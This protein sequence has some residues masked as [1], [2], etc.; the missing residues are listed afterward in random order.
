MLGI[1][2]RCGA[3]NKGQEMDKWEISPRMGLK[4]YLN[5]GGNVTIEQHDLMGEDSRVVV[6]QDD[7]PT[8]IRY[9]EEARQQLEQ[10][11]LDEDDVEEE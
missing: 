2:K 10:G 3:M 8:L 7:V 6:Y 9:L 1:Y 5:E 4:V 11:L